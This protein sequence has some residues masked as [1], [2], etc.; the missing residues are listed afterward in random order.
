VSNLDDLPIYI[1]GNPDSRKAVIVSYDIYG[2]EGLNHLFA[3][4]YRIWCENPYLGGRIRNIC[5]EIAMAGFFVILPDFLRYFDINLNK[6][7][8]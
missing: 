8:F 5:D 3:Y 6:W 7:S 2:F 4:S 1:V